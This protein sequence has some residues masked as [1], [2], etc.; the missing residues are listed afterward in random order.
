MQPSLAAVPAAAA[1]C[2]RSLMLC[3]PLAWSRMWGV[4]MAS[5]LQYAKTWRYWGLT[6]VQVGLTSTVC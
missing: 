6:V 3:R 4:A 5:T 2:G 1:R